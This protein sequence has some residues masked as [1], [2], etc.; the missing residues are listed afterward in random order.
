M[1]EY[2]NQFP[3][4][5]RKIVYKFLCQVEFISNIEFEEELTNLVLDNL[6]K[7]NGKIAFFPISKGPE[8]NRDKVRYSSG[9]K[10]GYILTNLERLFPDKIKVSP[11]ILEMRTQRYKS[12]VF[13]DDVIAS[14]ESIIKYARNKINK[15]I[16]SWSSLGYVNLYLLSVVGYPNGIN[17]ILENTNL[18]KS[19]N[20]YCSRIALNKSKIYN[21]ELTYTANKFGRLTNRSNLSIGFMESKGYHIFEHG[22]PNNIP[23]MLWAKGNK[24]NFKPL[25]KNRG[26]PLNLRYLFKKEFQIQ[27]SIEN[28]FDLNQPKLALRLITAI[29][30]KFLKHI[31]KEI[32]IVLSIS[33]IGVSEGNASQYFTNQRRLIYLIKLLKKQCVLNSDFTI[34]KYGRQILKKYKNFQVNNEIAGEQQYI[35]DIYLPDIFEGV[36]IRV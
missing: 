3:D 19:E 13:V 35:E 6:I 32:L 9:E 20:I 29:E 5:Y 30:N 17:R 18:F 11:S 24:N 28:I 1:N 25:F 15:S 10:I 31:E 26:I 2:L 33:S 7:I 8:N 27:Q 21:S 36:P 23:S 34:T 14:G 12:I 4:F 16:K 22:C